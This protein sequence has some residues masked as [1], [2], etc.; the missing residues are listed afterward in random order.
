MREAKELRKLS[1]SG[2]QA[3]QGWLWRR[4]L[5]LLSRQPLDFEEE[6]RRLLFGGLSL[7]ALGMLL[8]FGCYHLLV[9]P[10]LEGGLNLLVA[11]AVVICLWR[12]RGRTDGRCYYR[13]ASLLF[14]LLFVF[15]AL[16]GGDDGARAFWVL[17]YPA[18]A[19]FIGGSAFGAV[20]SLAL[21]AAWLLI[22]LLPTGL[23]G[24]PEYSAGFA[25]R[26]VA[27]YLTVFFIALHFERIRSLYSRAVLR[28]QRQLEQDKA[29][30]QASQELMR[31]MALSDDLTGIAN[32]R[33][34]LAQLDSALQEAGRSGRALTVAL[35]D[36]DFFKRVNDSFGHLVGDMVLVACVKRIRENIRCGDQLGRYGGEEFLLLLPDTGAAQATVLLDRVRCSIAEESVAVDGGE[37]EVTISIGTATSN[38]E[39]S[40]R[41]L[42]TAADNA[43]YWVKEHGRNQVKVG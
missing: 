9:G 19:F 11:L 1:Q 33:A 21:L 13:G 22:F 43:L 39:L 16:Q 7:V 36:I 2:E 41:E 27:S 3:P 30:L 34:I 26:F 5:A 31:I 12:L 23:T 17:T 29:A 37:V 4:I 15:F 35:L 40:A 24:A 10:L 6:Q 28:H 20:V 18:F 32:R 42:L 38:G 25:I 14:A 8:L